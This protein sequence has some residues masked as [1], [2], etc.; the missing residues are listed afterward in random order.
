MENENTGRN[1]DPKKFDSKD[2]S[3]DKGK[4]EFNA[5]GNDSDYDGGHPNDVSSQ[6]DGRINS[7]EERLNQEE[8][9]RDPGFNAGGNDSDYDGGHPEDVFPESKGSINSKQ[10]NSKEDQ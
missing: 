6:S 4:T 7:S 9:S 1:T 10:T 3:S 8:E 2:A 5:G